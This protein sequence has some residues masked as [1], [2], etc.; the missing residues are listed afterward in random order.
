MEMEREDRHER[1]QHVQ[2]VRIDDAK[3]AG[4]STTLGLHLPGCVARNEMESG[5]KR[6]MLTFKPTVFNRKEN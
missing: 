1:E 5:Y 4:E 3:K 6:G 2:D